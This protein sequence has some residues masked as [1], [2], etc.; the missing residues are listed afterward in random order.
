MQTAVFSGPTLSPAEV[1]AILPGG[2]FGPF[3]H[4][5]LI[6]VVHEL[7][8]DV[9]VLIDPDMHRQ[10]LW[11]KEVLHALDLGVLVCGAGGTGVLRAL[12]CE[13]YGA[14]AHGA[15]AEWFRS[16][17]LGDDEILVAHAGAEEHYQ[18]R[19]E[20][21]FNIRQTLAAAATTGVVSFQEA[22]QLLAAMKALHYPRRSYSALCD[23]ARDLPASRRDALA[24]FMADNATDHLRQDALE[25]LHLLRDNSAALPR[26]RARSREEARAKGGWFRSLLHCHRRVRRPGFGQAALGSIAAHAALSHP[27]FEE[28]NRQAMNHQLTQYLAEVLGIPL[29]A[30]DTETEVRR[31]RASRRLQSEADFLSWLSRNNLSLEEFQDWM[32]ELARARRLHRWWVTTKSVPE[33]NVVAVLQELR[34]QGLYP[35]VAD[36]TALRENVLERSG[37][38]VEHSHLPSNVLDLVREQ[39]RSASLRW[40]VPLAQAATEAGL[41]PAALL[42]E[43]QK[44][45][46][47]REAL[48][49]MATSSAWEAS[50]PPS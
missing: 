15:V 50:E 49:R 20:P 42:Y 39:M 22:N 9:V 28:I 33:R 37:L 40:H 27:E 17:N 14:V 25:L 31:F 32:A 45:F 41:P 7:D 16:G 18:R 5:D 36:Q 13:P 43:L 30:A 46:M 12:E 2:T 4:A 21:L 29:D 48:T 24:E 35:E 44:E 19:S 38:D 47:A 8:L 6:S 23:L 26:P 11:P 1:Q 3:R 34:L 10:A